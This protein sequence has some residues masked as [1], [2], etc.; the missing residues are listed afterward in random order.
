MADK[1]RVGVIGVGQIGKFHLHRYMQMPDVEVVAICDINEPELERVAKLHNIPNTYYWFRELLERDDIEAV[2][3]CLHNNLHAPVTV[4]ALQAGKHVYC[5]KPMAGTFIDA[6]WMYRT[7]QETGKKLSI[8]L[9]MLFTKETKSA[10]ILIDQGM[11]GKIYH[12]RST[13]FRRRGRPYVDGY[14]SIHF[15]Q[16][17]YAAGGAM[18]DMGVYHITQ[19][20]YLLGNPTVERITGKTYQELEMDAGRKA[21][22][23]YDV[24]ELGM[25]F[26][27]FQDG[28]T[29]DIIESWAIQLD[30]FEG[31][32]LV[33]TSGGIRLE[34]FGYFSTAGDV[35][36]SA[37]ADMSAYDDRIHLMQPT[38]DAYDN[39]QKH[40]IAALRGRV[41]LLPTAELALNSMLITEGIYLSSR[42]GREVSAEEIRTS[43]NSKAFKNL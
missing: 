2:D 12:S 24:E 6:E 23:G 27:Y 9:N 43:S 17:E 16:S 25:G 28:L 42:L 38:A 14:G 41:P 29:M 36:L 26:V 39:P 33:G 8:Q 3:V 10:R 34:P 31:S 32:S 5:E 15:V 37:T 30:G 13:G 35:D 22:S 20:L 1:I 21:E 7:A 11:L 4:A 40:W 19:L 18:F